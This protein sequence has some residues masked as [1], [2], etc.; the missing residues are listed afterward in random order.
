MND[1]LLQ[2]YHFSSVDTIYK[3]NKVNKPVT[4]IF[5]EKL[6]NFLLTFFYGAYITNRR[7]CLM[8]ARNIRTIYKTIQ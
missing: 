7:Y 8:P 3:S 2:N 5:F 1:I 6:E 4:L